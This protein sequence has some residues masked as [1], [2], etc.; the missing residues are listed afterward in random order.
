MGS[1]EGIAP[2][3]EAAYANFPYAPR[4]STHTVGRD[5]L[6]G[7]AG[8]AAAFP[9]AAMPSLSP[10][11]SGAAS[12]AAPSAGA[13]ATGEST[14]H[15]FAF[16]VSFVSSVLF[17]MF[18]SHMV[19]VLSLGLCFLSIGIFAIVRRHLRRHEYS[20]VTSELPSFECVRARPPLLALLP[21]L[22]TAAR[23][24]FRRVW[25]LVAPKAKSRGLDNF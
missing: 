12:S 18:F 16:A 19:A 17:D 23:T 24:Q 8:A 13:I 6:D 21:L 7:R 15:G 14:A 11:S 20:F 5:V 9:S 22:R 4:D 3:S 25:E 2:L 1:A 10:G